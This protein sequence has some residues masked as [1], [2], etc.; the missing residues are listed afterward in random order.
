M[1]LTI[2]L[3]WAL[4]LFLLTF[5]ASDALVAVI[6]PVVTVFICPSYHYLVVQFGVFSSIKKYMIDPYYDEHPDADIE[7]RRN[8]GLDVGDETEA[9]FEDLI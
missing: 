3:Y 1:F 4:W 9:D 6:L 8:L 2:G 7:Q 5:F